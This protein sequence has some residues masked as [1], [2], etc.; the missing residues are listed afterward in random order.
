MDERIWSLPGPR[1]LIT[2]TVSELE[3][4][5][6]IFLA[7]PSGMAANPAV[8]DSLCDAVAN[9]AGRFT[10][11]RRIFAE[12][13][14]D[15]L[16][17]VIARAVDFDDPPATV[18]ELLSHYQSNGVTF[19][20]VAADHNPAQQSEFPKF[21]ERVEQETRSAPADVRLALVVAGGRDH[22]PSFRG[23][24]NSDVSLATLWWWN[25]IARW[26]TAAH[27]SHI[28]GP[29]IEDRILAD[30]RAETI[31]EVAR[32][33]LTL[34]ERL[35]HDWSG[36]PADLPEHLQETA[37]P[38]QPAT[39]SR[40]RCGTRPAESLL[41]LWDTGQLDGWHDDYSPVPSR[42]RLRRLVWAAQARI[43]LP[44][45]EQR[46]EVLQENTIAKMGRRRFTEQ[47]QLMFDPPLPDAG[48]VEI[49]DLYKI[50]DARLGK[51]EPGMRSTARRLRDARNKAAHL[52]HLTLGELGELVNACRDLY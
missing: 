50:I 38:D 23:G 5:R 27:I 37:P 33:N 39:E 12:P 29:L 21:L 48:L 24:E 25:R 36:D 52:N 35:A 20:V 8:T 18:P 41:N 15:S 26:D 47:L 17:E 14:A 51:H 9:E 46:R 1:T 34:A 44:W 16:L 30:I 7:L 13:D 19:V 11:T 6:H 10:T 32:W 28:D 42:Q 2:D 3:A 43:V 49:G 40:E 31:V 45:I 22:L 4:G